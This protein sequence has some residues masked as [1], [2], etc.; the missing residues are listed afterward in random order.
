MTERDSQIETYRKLN[1][2]HLSVQSLLVR[3]FSADGEVSQSIEV[4]L[5]DELEDTL[6]YV[7]TGIRDL[8]IADLH[9]GVKCKL[10]IVNIASRQFEGLKYQVF[11]GDQDFTLSFWCREFV[12]SHS[13]ANRL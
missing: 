7:F 8:R 1:R 6:V 3:Q 4:V 2:G 10:E 13:P 12:A 5:G 11:N 9:P